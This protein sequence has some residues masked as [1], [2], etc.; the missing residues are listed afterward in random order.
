MTR[1]NRIFDLLDQYREQFPEKKDVLVHKVNGQW[2]NISTDEYIKTSNQVSA[3]LLALGIR[4][5]DRIATILNNSPY[6]NFLDMGLLQIGAVQVPI[7]PT[8]SEE[9]YGHIFDE[10]EVRLIFITNLDIY[11]KIK[12]VVDDISSLQGIYSIEKIEG[13]KNWSEFI[14]LGTA[15]DYTLLEQTKKE[16]LHS[17]LATIIYTSGTTGKSKGVMLSHLNFISNFLTLSEIIRDNMVATA[18]SFLPLCH[19]YERVLN[20]MYQNVG[21]SVYYAESIEK[22]GDN[23]REVH[24]ELFCAV[25]R[26]IEKSFNRIMA[27]GRDLKGIKRML[28]FW[29][30]NL[31]NHFELDHANGWWYHFKLRIADKL[32]FSKWREALGG[33]LDIIVSGGA[34]LQERLARIFWACGIRIME[35]YGLTETSPVIAVSNFKPGGVRFGTVGY[36]L[37]GLQV[38][39][40]DDGEI[41]CKG[42][43]VMLGYYKHP[44]LTTQVIDDGGWFHTGDIG[45]FVDG[46]YLKITDRKKE[47]FKTSGGKYIA[48]QVLEN[49]FKESPFIENI[50][51]IGENRHFT[52]AIITPNFEHLRSWCRVKGLPYTTDGDAIANERI[53]ARIQR[54]VDEINVRLD[55]IEQI[56]KFELLDKSWTVEEGDLSPTLKLRRNVLE[57]KYKDIIEEMYACANMYH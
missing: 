1:I 12:R 51:V 22:I 53:V 54:A 10:T 9:N 33:K 25:P 30:V 32:V 18:M 44:E 50:M 31:G 35:G 16:I 7:Y 39:I 17:D 15:D 48:P 56:K 42:P 11:E 57:L 27:K 36:A 5:G 2:E 3:A 45:T 34:T 41:L 14:S 13:L 52:S 26:V 49:K 4:K 6:W 20:Y 43:N 55:K 38:R 29:A 37:P 8:I 21:I 46:K 23:L 19:V 47:I 28:F 24:P 40:A